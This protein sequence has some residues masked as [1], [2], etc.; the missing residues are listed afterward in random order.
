MSEAAEQAKA[1]GMNL[2]GCTLD[3]VEKVAGWRSRLLNAV[4][5]MCH[6]NQIFTSDAVEQI[7]RYEI[8]EIEGR[9]LL[10]LGSVMAKAAKLGWCRKANC[11]PTNSDRVSCHARALTVWESLI[12]GEDL[13]A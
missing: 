2:A 10:A 5:T 8:D 13:L 12:Y 7:V 6:E 4:R 9:T 1:E 11:A 3:G